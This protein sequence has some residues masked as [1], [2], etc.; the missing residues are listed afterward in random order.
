MAPHHGARGPATGLTVRMVR[1][2]SYQ[3]LVRVQAGR[4]PPV[5]RG[6][7]GPHGVGEDPVGGRPG[8][9]RNPAGFGP[10]DAPSTPT[11]SMPRSTRFDGGALS[12]SSGP[13]A[14]WIRYWIG[15]V[16]PTTLA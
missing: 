15:D 16:K 4:I 2:H 10:R 11:R 6:G 9:S 7:T 12:Y 14:R 3:D 5:R 13:V 8:L 1:R